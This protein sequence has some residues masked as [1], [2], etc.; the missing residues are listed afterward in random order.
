M[1]NCPITSGRLEPCNDS[2]GGLDAFYAIPYVADAFT[3][4]AGQ[5]TS[6]D[7]G[8]TS[9]YKF[10]LRADANTFTYDGA[11]DENTGVLLYTE[12]LTVFLKKQDAATNVQVDLLS[13][14]LHYFIVKNRNGDYQL[15][16]SLDG[17]RSTATNNTSGGARSDGNGYNLTMTSYSKIAAP[18]LDETTVTALLAIVS[19]DS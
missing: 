19:P 11:S 5:V 4:D 16:G 14:G 2:I 12:T 8:I 1:A 18:V 3:V 6:I 9:A 13:Q 10:E 17:A 15:M 7:A